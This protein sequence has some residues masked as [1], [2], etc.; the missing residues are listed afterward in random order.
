MQACD[1]IPRLRQFGDAPAIVW[2]ET[3][4]S[5]SQLLTTWEQQLAALRDQGIGPG[6]CVAIVGDFSP[7]TTAMLLALAVNGN[8][9]VPLTRSVLT[10]EELQQRLVYASSVV[11]F[12]ERDQWQVRARDDAQDHPLLDQLRQTE[13]PG[14]I[15]FSSGSTG[16]AKASLHSFNRLLS[17][18]AEKRRS[19]RMLTFLLLDHMGGINTLLSVLCNGGVA[20]TTRQRSAE[21]IC[22]LVERH[23]IELL[24][25]TPTFLNMLLISEAYKRHDLSSLKFMSFGTEAMPESTLEALQQT[26]PDVKFRQLYGMT[27]L[28][29]LPSRTHEEDGL[30]LKLGGDG[31]EV[32][33]VDGVLWV[34]ASTAMMGYLNAPS[35]FDEDGWFNTG[36]AVVEEDGYL[37]ILGRDSEMINVGGEKVFPAEVENAILGVE[38]VRDVAVRGKPNPITGTIIVARVALRDPEEKRAVE[39][40]I[41]VHCKEKLAPFKIPAL[42]EIADGPLHGTRFKKKRSLET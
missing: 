42:I 18:F 17:P 41:R 15:L 1:I 16:V 6:Q 33:V 4:Y 10:D 26:F 22:E 13:E 27:E 37:R 9:I 36:D 28:G 11:E 30:R 31:C 35:M 29:I 19:F 39:R 34:R 32:K 7:G 2:N 14:L 23:R 20:V 12:D 25:A 3:T 8:I 24:P 38:N 40:R 5:Y 21:A